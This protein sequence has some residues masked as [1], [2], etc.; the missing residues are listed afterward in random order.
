MQSKT[1][2]EFVV[3]TEARPRGTRMLVD[4]GS[5]ISLC[6]VKKIAARVPDPEHFAPAPAPEIVPVQ[7]P[8][9]GDPDDEDLGEDSDDDA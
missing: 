5:A 2:I 4:G 3:D 6:D 7:V 9:V 1:L 8:A